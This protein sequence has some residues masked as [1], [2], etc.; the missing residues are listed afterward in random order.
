MGSVDFTK[1]NSHTM[2]YVITLGNVTK[3]GKSN[4]CA[5]D[6]YTMTVLPYYNTECGVFIRNGWSTHTDVHRQVAMNLRERDFTGEGISE[7]I[8]EIMLKA[9]DIKFE[10]CQIRRNVS[11]RD[12][13]KELR[14]VYSVVSLI[15]SQFTV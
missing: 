13:F 12:F 15:F 11:D 7:R 8:P 5:T 1:S 14:A 10:T 9:Y 2:Q 6:V 3:E 4:P